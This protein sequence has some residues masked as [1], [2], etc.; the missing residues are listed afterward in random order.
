MSYSIEIK[1]NKPVSF[2]VLLQTL[3][4]ERVEI[5]YANEK[6]TRKEI[7]NY[8]RLYIYG[9]SSRGIQVGLNEENYEI[10]INV[11]CSEADYFLATRIASELATLSDS[12]II[13]QVS[14][15]EGKIELTIT[16]F[17]EHFNHKWAQKNC[18]MGTG[19]FR[20]LIKER[21]TMMISGCIRS[22][23]MGP[24]LLSHHEKKNLSNEKIYQIIVKRIMLVQ[25]LPSSIH[26]P[27]EY[28]VTEEDG[29][30]WN[31]ITLSFNQRQLVSK[32]EFVLL[33]IS[34]DEYLKVPF[35][36]FQ[37]YCQRQ[38]KRLDEEQYLMPKT[39]LS[40]FKKLIKK[41][42]IAKTKSSPPKKWWKF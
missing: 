39:S 19:A 20:N 34:E 27:T 9:K 13:P 4:R 17:K 23:Y 37:K 28:V 29:S 35:T 18:T 16:E 1:K 38:Y 2:D 40:E 3:K 30:N 25:F 24:E 12:K 21:G 22:S 7:S 5:A 32:S 26:I 36:D 15:I 33:Y 41:F 6:F 11:L 14:P 10:M 8:S 31:Y 42:S